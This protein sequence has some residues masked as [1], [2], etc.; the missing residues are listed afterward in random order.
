MLLG[1]VYKEDSSEVG[2]PCYGKFQQVGRYS[3]QRGLAN[4]H[5]KGICHTI[6][7]L[8]FGVKILFAASATRSQAFT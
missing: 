6:Q 3:V 7:A 2:W 4:N 1:F 8:W 5:L